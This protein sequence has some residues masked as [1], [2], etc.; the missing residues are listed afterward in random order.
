MRLSISLMCFMLSLQETSLC[1]S[2]ANN[3]S[4]NGILTHN[5]SF[6]QNRLATK[7]TGVLRDGNTH[8]FILLSL[9]II[10]SSLLCIR[11]M[12]AN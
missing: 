12:Q 7:I 1:C 3:R 9:I 6:L 8:S 4:L 10:M 11:Y 2:T 5:Y